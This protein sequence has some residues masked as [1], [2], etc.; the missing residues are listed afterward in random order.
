MICIAWPSSI[1][2]QSALVKEYRYIEGP[3]PFHCY[4]R[5]DRST[6]NKPCKR[7]LPPCLVESCLHSLS[8]SLSLLPSLRC[9]A[10]SAKYPFEQ[11]QCTVLRW[12]KEYSVLEWSK[13]YARGH[14]T[15]SG[16]RE[17]SLFV[18]VL[19]SLFDALPISLSCRSF[20][21]SVVQSFSRSVVCKVDKDLDLLCRKSFIH[22]FISSF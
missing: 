1:I 6:Q 22:L 15:A 2:A 7:V 9:F 14:R 8:L 3:I 16:R 21:R 13:T 11:L 10:L 19:F 12:V 17:R 5:E 20:N 18:S 4:P